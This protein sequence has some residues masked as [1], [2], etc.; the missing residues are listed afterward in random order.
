MFCVNCGAKLENDARFCDIC[1]TPQSQPE[2]VEEMPV[3]PEAEQAP[4]EA[5]EIPTPEVEVAPVEEPAAQPVPMP[6]VPA[7]PVY[8]PPVQPVAPPAPAKQPYRPRPKP[9][10]ALRIPL[11]ILSFIL[12]FA[13]AFSLLGTVLLADL[14]HLMSAGGIKQLINAVLMPNAA[15]T[16][17]IRP[18]AGAL[19][20]HMGQANAVPDFTIPG[21]LDIG[22]DDIP[23]DLFQ[24]GNLDMEGLIDWIYDAV[25]EAT[26]EPLPVT[27]EQVASFIAESTLSDFVA[28]KLAGYAE[29][30]I[31][32]TENTTITTEELLELLDENQALLEDKFQ[33]EITPEVKENLTASVENAMAETDL[34]TAIREQV[35]DTVAESI[36]QTMQEAG[37]R[38]EDLQALLQKICS[39]T[40]LYAAIGTCLVLMLLLCLVNF[41]NIPGGLTWI[42]VPCI[43]MG[44]LAT[45]PLLLLTASP[46]I[47]ADLLPGAVT[48]LVASFAGV[49]LPIHASVPILGLT[50]LIVSIIWRSVR[51]AIR[52]SRLRASVA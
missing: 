25:Q 21:D 48:G 40:T 45:L 2:P 43:F 13:L 15:P 35:F 16:Q 6:E 28:E 7:Q 32:G 33:I 31:N 36:D 29:D 46:E 49:L 19:G 5:V 26:E 8:M 24:G 34:N 23:E 17:H 3:P 11:Q 50:L 47:F 37:M 38:W 20:V 52:R 42:A 18:A 10:I 27:K 12:S 39:D 22:L 41:Y 30:F 44:T 4:L 9:H 14:N 1:G 51:T